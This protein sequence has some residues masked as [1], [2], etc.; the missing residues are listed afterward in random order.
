MCDPSVSAFLSNSHLPESLWVVWNVHFSEGCLEA[1]YR[2][3]KF[4]ICQVKYAGSEMNQGIQVKGVRKER[5][6]MSE[7]QI[8][9]SLLPTQSPDHTSMHFSNHRLECNFFQKKKKNLHF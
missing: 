5:A 2:R 7:T 8:A 1:G 9:L 4:Q 3:F 6:G